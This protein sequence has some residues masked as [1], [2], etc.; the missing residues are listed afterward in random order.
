MRKQVLRASEETDYMYASVD[1]VSHRLTRLLRKYKDR[2]LGKRKVESPFEEDTE[3]EIAALNAAATTAA[4][5]V[6]GVGGDF[7]DPAKAVDMRVVKRKQFDMPPMTVCV[8]V[9]V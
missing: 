1:L 7:E 5:G 3:A 9:C 4:G 8:G 2:K 6:A